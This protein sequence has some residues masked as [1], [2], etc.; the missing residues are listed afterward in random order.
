[1]AHISTYGVNGEVEEQNQLGEEERPELP[2]EGE[3]EFVDDDGTL[4]R[5]DHTLR[6]WVPQN[7]VVPEGPSYGADE[8]TF[9]DEEEVMPSLKAAIASGEQQE[10]AEAVA[11]KAESPEPAPKKRKGEPRGKKEGATETEGWFELKVNT[12]VYVTGLPEDATVDEVVK[13]FT[14]CGY[15]KEDLDTKKPRV[16]LYYDKA[17]GRQKGDALVTYLKEPSVDLA[18]KILDGTSLRPGDKEL[19]TVTRA[20]FEQKGEVFVKKQSNQQK[21]KKLKLREEKALGWGGFDDAKPL[22]PMTVILKNM[23]TRQQL[24]ADPNLLA[25]LET[26]IADE[27]GKLGAIERLRV[28]DSHPDGVAMVKFKDKKAGEKCVK[29]MNGRWFGGRQISAMEDDGLIN[30]GMVR[31]AA[32]EAARLEQFGAELEAD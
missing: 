13:V 24:I 26:D 8:M 32:E 16:K 25:E 20:K 12:H 7:E 1:M 4:Y 28:Y 29:L 9:V 6:A 11:P 21:K 30:Y 2:P 23:F 22:E 10:I 15:I 27:C 31:D 17:T 3:T 18:L 14:K 5:W 19:M